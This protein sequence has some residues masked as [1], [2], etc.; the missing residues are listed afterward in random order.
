[1]KTFTPSNDQIKFIEKV[2]NAIAQ[3]K[4]CNYTIQDTTPIY[5]EFTSKKVTQLNKWYKEI[6][7][8]YLKKQFQRL[9]KQYGYV[10]KKLFAK[11]IF[12]TFTN[13][14][15]YKGCD[16]SMNW[17]VWEWGNLD[18]NNKI[19]LCYSLAKNFRK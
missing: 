16:R 5:Q 19:F 14:S 8:P 17:I 9:Y 1:M 6:Q 11:I 13:L 12:N 7:H 15:Y 3:A 4:Q 10:D 2:N 18:T